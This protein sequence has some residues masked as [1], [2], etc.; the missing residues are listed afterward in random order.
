MSR[1]DEALYAAK[2]Q[3]RNRT[4]LKAGDR[5][6]TVPP[7]QSRSLDSQADKQVAI[8]RRIAAAGNTNLTTVAPAIAEAL[9]ATAI[10]LAAAIP[11]YIAYNKFSGEAGKLSSRMEGFADEFSAILSRQID[12]KLQPRQAAQ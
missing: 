6:V 4:S 5:I 7:A 2:K 11:A 1:A 9:F 8:L 3:G 10:G 12:E